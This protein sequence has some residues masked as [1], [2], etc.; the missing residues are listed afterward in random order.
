MLD[1][2]KRIPQTE[3]REFKSKNLSPDEAWELMLHDSSAMLV[4]VRTNEEYKIEHIEE[5]IC[6]PLN[7]ILNNP[8]SVC[9]N[10]NTPIILYCQKGY[11]SS[12]AAQALVDAGYSRIYTIPGIGQYQYNLTQ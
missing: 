10:K 2:E 7:E 4:D 5:S 8:F 6:I 1:R 9:S 11:K 12:A 3:G